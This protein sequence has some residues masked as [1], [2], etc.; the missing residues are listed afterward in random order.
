MATLNKHGYGQGIG[1][2]TPPSKNKSMRSNQL[3][4]HVPN[5]D[6]HD[7][8]TPPDKIKTKKKK[9]E[10]KSDSEKKKKSSGTQKGDDS[11][12]PLN[13]EDTGLCL[14]HISCSLPVEL[15]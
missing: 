3:I 9:K 1:H 10:K 2:G 14:I 5:S 8:I 7:K 6:D 13:S 15:G 12:S 4:K 11:S